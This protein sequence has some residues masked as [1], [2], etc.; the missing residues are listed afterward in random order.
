MKDG[1]KMLAV[2]RVGRHR[3]GRV[4]TSRRRGRGRVSL[5]GRRSASRRIHVDRK[6]GASGK[7]V[8]RPR[9]FPVGAFVMEED[10]LFDVVAV[11]LFS[12]GAQM[13]QACDC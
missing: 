6:R 10:E 7:R 2:G 13:A 8:F 9:P 4:A 3:F 12:S 1:A 11:S 5:P